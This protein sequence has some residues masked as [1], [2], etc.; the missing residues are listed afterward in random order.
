MAITARRRPAYLRSGESN[1]AHTDVILPTEAKRELPTVR[2]IGLL[3]LRDA[4][5]LGVQDF[6]AMPT[7][8]VFLS[9][10]YPVIGL[11]LF[12]AMFDYDLIPLLYPLAAGFPLIGPFAAIGLYELSRRRELGLDTSWRHAFDFVHSPSLWSILFLGLLLLLM[13]GVWLAIAQALYDANFG[14]DEPL[15]VT[16]FARRVFTTPEGHRLI[17]VGNAIGFGFAV[18][19]FCLSVVTF[20]L[21]L[22][23]NVGVGAAIA[24]SFRVILRNP[25]PM[26][27]WAIF[28]AGLLVIGSLPFFLGLAI[29]VPILGHSTWHLYRKVI[30]PDPTPRPQYEPRPRG[31]RYAADFPAALFRPTSL[32]QEKPAASVERLA[33]SATRAADRNPAT[34]E[35]AQAVVS[36]VESLFMPWNVDALVEG[37]TEDCIVRFGT[38]PEFRGRDALRRF[39]VARSARQKGYRLRKQFRSLMDDVMSN[40]WEGEWEDTETGR[41]MKGYGVEVWTMRGG[42][43][44]I[45]EASFNAGPADQ[46]VDVARMLG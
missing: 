6:W 9:L 7:H 25:G 32:P 41:R 31:R 8:V 43:I 40:V 37:F 11:A 14:S 21:L 22:D 29:V 20:P 45:W 13:V 19:A 42:K 15:K 4:L 26:I 2:S 18:L 28:V 46:S 44:A 5:A 27:L 34:I 30:E 16:D 10:I 35:E 33:A 38:I 36:H 1:M 17:V 39:F 12:R 3:D 24:T 23:R